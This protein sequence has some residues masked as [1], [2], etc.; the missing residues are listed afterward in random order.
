[1]KLNEHL[2]KLSSYKAIVES[3]SMREAARRLNITQ[4][5]LSKMVAALEAVVGKSLLVRGRNGVLPTESGKKLYHYSLMVL[6]DLADLEQKLLHP[7]DEKAGHLRVGG[8][9]SLAEYLWPHFVPY[10]KKDAP[11][12]RLSL[13]TSETQ[14]R[15]LNN[16]EIDLLVDA[17][18]RQTEDI[19]SWKLYEDKFNFYMSASK[20]KRWNPDEVEAMPLIYSPVAFDSENKKIILHIEEKNYKFKEIFEL[21]SFMA[22]I[23]FAKKGLGLAVL[24]SRLAEAAVKSGELVVVP[25]RGFPA[26]GFGVHHFAASVSETR[27]DDPRIKYFIKKLRDW[28]GEH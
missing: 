27:K 24:P 12:L 14:N 3:G 9:A 5:A 8:Y 15:S 4:P 10:L 1:M 16:G 21:D 19:I 6:R 28:V 23:A 11:N 17:E 13:F 22:V 7:A 25:M 2:D 26:R 18:P 20:A